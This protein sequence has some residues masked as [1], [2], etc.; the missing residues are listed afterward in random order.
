MLPR[1]LLLLPLVLCDNIHS[2]ERQKLVKYKENLAMQIAEFLHIGS[3][4]GSDG[5]E[6]LPLAKIILEYLEFDDNF[7]W[8]T[9]KVIHGKL[10]TCGFYNYPNA[11][12]VKK[13]GLYVVST[14]EKRPTIAY[15]KE[16]PCAPKALEKFNGALQKQERAYIHSSCNTWRL[17]YVPEKEGN[18]TI[19]LQRYALTPSGC[20]IS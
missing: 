13:T 17:Q 14:Q 19:I 11:I 5:K 15:F 10:M 2:A 3:G 6:N 16:V 7:G 18:D 20:T 4:K 12:F 8:V 1:L 9:K